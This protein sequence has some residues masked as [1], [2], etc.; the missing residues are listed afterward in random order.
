MKRNAL[1][2]LSSVLLCS[3]GGG[4]K[5]GSDG[6]PTAPPPNPTAAVQGVWNG[7]STGTLVHGPACIG[8]PVS[9]PVKAVITQSGSNIALSITLN[10]AITCSFHGTVGATSIGW[11]FD[12]Q[13]ANP[14]CLGFRHLPC[15]NANGSI[16]FIDSRLRKGDLDGSVS[17]NQILVTGDSITDILDSGTGQV[18]DTLEI[19]GKTQLQKQ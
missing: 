1:I 14:D 19:M 10:S 6:G 8:N 4:G 7:T 17:G 3:C 16:R 9:T 2:F 18:I 11:T 5:G 15:R 13:Q 12:Q